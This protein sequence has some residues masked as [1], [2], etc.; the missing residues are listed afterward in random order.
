MII[1]GPAF[2]VMRESVV[3]PCPDHLLPVYKTNVISFNNKK[4]KIKVELK[5][6]YTYTRFSK[7]RERKKI[8]WQMK[9]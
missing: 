7:R 1:R 9:L 5:K 2:A 8:G 3:I 6:M 4:R